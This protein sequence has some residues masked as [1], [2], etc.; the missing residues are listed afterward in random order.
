MKQAI[1]LI[2]LSFCFHF[3]EAQTKQKTKKKHAPIKHIKVRE[4][5]FTEP[6]VKE[7]PEPPAP[8]QQDIIYLEESRDIVPN[9]NLKVKE[10]EIYDFV[11]QMPEFPGGENAL[12]KYID[13]HI[14]YPTKAL[15]L[16]RQG[17]V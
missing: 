2:T 17:K 3:C 9:D 12:K 13:V 10:R 16:F 14:K 8:Q 11:E 5:K 4:I 7:Y 1:L 6:K 15:E